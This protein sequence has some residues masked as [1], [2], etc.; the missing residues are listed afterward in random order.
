MPI[1]IAWNFIFMAIALVVPVDWK[2]HI[3]AQSVVLFQYFAINPLLGI[4]RIPG[5]INIFDPDLIIAALWTC[6][7]CDVAVCIYDRLQYREFESRRELRLFI[8]AI[9]HDLQI[10]VL[11]TAVVLQ[12]LLRKAQAA[13]GNALI[14]TSKLEKL[15]AGNDRQLNL[16]NS[17]LT[18]HQS[19]TQGIILNCQPIAFSEVIESVLADLEARLVENQIILTNQI[20]ADLPLIQA[21]KAQLWRVVSNLIAN[22]ITHNPAGIS[23]TLDAVASS[24][25][26]HCTIEDSG[27]GIPVSQQQRLFELYYRG[28]RSRYMPGLGLGL[29]VCRK[30]ITAHGGRIGLMSQPGKGSTFWFTLPIAA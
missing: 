1:P 23:L 24:Q 19:A 6:T 11:G 14:T 25:F 5:L 16:I 26:L 21:D 18:A 15:L 9:T 30:I 2:L 28:E 29:H 4:T 13:D 27:L 22:A 20:P 8:H 10:P 3:L 7:I 17:I 12:S